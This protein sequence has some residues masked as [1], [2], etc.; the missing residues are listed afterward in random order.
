MNLH[1]PSQHDAVDEAWKKLMPS[2][3]LFS[4][5]NQDQ[6]VPI[7]KQELILGLYTANKRESKAKHTFAT[8]EEALNAIRTGSI[9]LSDDVEIRGK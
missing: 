8:E 2:K 6:V 1:V 4:I 5:R 9:S 3:M 7:P